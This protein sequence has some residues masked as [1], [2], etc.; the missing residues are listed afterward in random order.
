MIPN[1]PNNIRIRLAELKLF[2]LHPDVA[3]LNWDSQQ[4]RDLATSGSNKKI[5]WAHLIL[6]YEESLV[7]SNLNSK[8][9]DRAIVDVKKAPKSHQ[10]LMHAKNLELTNTLILQTWKIAPIL[11]GN[12]FEFR[13]NWQSH[14]ITKPFL[15][16]PSTISVPLLFH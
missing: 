13:R 14:K 3:K 11:R 16:E 7:S 15:E 9:S 8:H 6:Y 1:F 12:Q 5:S 4:C 10:Y 2:L